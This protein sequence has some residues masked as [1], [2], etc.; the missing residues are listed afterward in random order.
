MMAKVYNAERRPLWGV[1]CVN[2]SATEAMRILAQH[3]HHAIT[4][5]EGPESNAQ[6][7]IYEITCNTGL[8]IVKMEGDL[9]LPKSGFVN[10]GTCPVCG[11]N[12]DGGE[13]PADIK[14]HYNE[15]YRWSRLISIEDPMIY[16]GI[17]WY[18]CP[19][20]KSQ[21]D[22]WTRKLTHLKGVIQ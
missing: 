18:R 4:H 20:C 13:I 16:D 12:W 11:S 1:K 14:E 10:L 3:G 5:E 6:F 19:D 22:R 2:D 7:R 9:S 8:F 17:S 21:W 15:P